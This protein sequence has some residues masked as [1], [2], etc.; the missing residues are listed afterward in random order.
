MRSMKML[1]IDKRIVLAHLFKG[2]GRKVWPIL[3]E[4]FGQIM[5]VRNL[6]TSNNIDFKRT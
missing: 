6:V 3:G 4:I 5:F 1:G 2:E